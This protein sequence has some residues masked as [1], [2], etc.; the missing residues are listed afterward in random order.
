MGRLPDLTA[1][2]RLGCLRLPP[3][4]DIAYLWKVTITRN[5]VIQHWAM[6]RNNKYVWNREKY[7]SRLNEADT[8]K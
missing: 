2:I 1:D 6:G 4:N 8:F 5:K 7:F 3:I